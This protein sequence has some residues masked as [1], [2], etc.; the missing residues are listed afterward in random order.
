MSKCAFLF[1]GQGAQYVGMGKEMA[2]NYPSARAIFE[3]ADEVLG[4]KIS[5]IIFQGEKKD[6]RK[7]EITQPAVLITS[8]AVLSVLREEGIYPEALAGLSL[9][10]YSAL[11][12]AGVISFSDALL[13]VQKRSQ[14][15]QEAVPLG[16]GGMAAILG[17]SSEEVRALCERS[18]P[19]GHVEPANY[20]CPGQIVI[21][22]HMKAVEEVCRLAKEKKAR[23]VALSVSVPFHCRLLFPIKEKMAT[24]LGNVS[25]KKP[26]IPFVSNV[27]ANYLWDPEEIRR[28]LVTQVYSPVY[29]EDSMR[30]LLKDGY[31][32]FIETGPGRVLTGFMKK[33]SREVHAIHVE[34]RLTLERLKTFLKGGVTLDS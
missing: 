7:T 13:I 29:W 24:F 9:G 5:K 14:Y 31:D 10:E 33:I 8:I 25:F 17:L 1:P 34:D 32:L 4:F 11:V 27:C 18:M 21:A 6:L 19:L 28:A 22:G 12:C 3:E 16:K 23:A 20:N 2:E 30:L 15:M 26:D